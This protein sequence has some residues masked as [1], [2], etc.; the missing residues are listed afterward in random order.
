MRQSAF[1]SLKSVPESPPSTLQAQ[2]LCGSRPEI[3]H[4][5]LEKVLGRDRRRRTASH[6]NAVFPLSRTHHIG[7]GYRSRS[8]RCRSLD[9]RM[10]SGRPGITGAFRDRTAE[11]SPITTTTSPELSA[12]ERGIGSYCPFRITWSTPL[13]WTN[14]TYEGTLNPTINLPRWHSGRF[15]TAICCIRP[16]YGALGDLPE[17]RTFGYRWWTRRSASAVAVPEIRMYFRAVARSLHPISA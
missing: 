11:R 13:H 4:G 7:P 6:R 8:P 2:S 12:G 16:L 14:L 1:V 9:R 3:P 17:E 5:R 15:E 10:V